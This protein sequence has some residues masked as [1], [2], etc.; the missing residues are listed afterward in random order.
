MPRIIVGRPVSRK[1]VEAAVVHLDS[2]RVLPSLYSLFVLA[3][4]VPRGGK[5]VKKPITGEGYQLAVNEPELDLVTAHALDARLPGS[6]SIIGIQ[7][8]V[9]GLRVVDVDYGDWRDLA[10]VH[11]PLLTLP[12]LKAG[13][14]HL[15]YVATDR[16]DAPWRHDNRPYEMLNCRGELRSRRGW[17]GV[18]GMDW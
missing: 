5:M 4:Q 7:P 18:Y 16:D 14:R 11:E 6:M 12:T 3:K 15:Y 1:L 8:C 10:R 13:R 2:A 17:A 9:L